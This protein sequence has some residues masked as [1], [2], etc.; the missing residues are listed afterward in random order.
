M[1][2]AN[3]SNKTLLFILFFLLVVSI[4]TV[5]AVEKVKVNYKETLF[6]QMH[7]MYSQNLL[8]MQENFSNLKCYVTEKGEVVNQECLDFYN[9]FLQDIPIKNYCKSKRINSC[10][11]NYKVSGK[12]PKNCDNIY[13]KLINKLN[14]SVILKKDKLMI[15]A[16]DK[17]KKYP[18][19]AIDINGFNS[20][21]VIGEDL[22]IVTLRKKYDGE[23][24]IEIN[25][26]ICEENQK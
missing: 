20:P 9:E 1:K 8:K 6:L 25:S 10:L 11:P 24:H 14:D 7:S 22:I 13:E 15:I 21:N 17:E 5:K 23:Y 19:F 3:N 4:A 12:T 16:S 2:E 26:T 18:V